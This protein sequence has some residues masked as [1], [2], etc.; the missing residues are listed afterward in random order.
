MRWCASHRFD[1]AGA[2]LADRH[3]SRVKIGSPQFAP[4]GSCCVFLTDCGRGLWVTSAPQYGRHEW[5]GAWVN[6]LFRSE[7]A[8]VASALIREAIAATRA[9]LGDP[10]ANGMITFI[11][12]DM[13]R[14]TK[15]RGR[16]VWGW[17]YRKAGFVEVGETKINRHLVLQMLPEAMPA[18][19]QARQRAVHGMPLFDRVAS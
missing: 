1:P 19:A 17:C 12:R 8:G 16:D 14:P 11:N 18:P 13:V 4:L 6:S 10:P 7:G 2:R 5:R 15:V 9:A 3:Y